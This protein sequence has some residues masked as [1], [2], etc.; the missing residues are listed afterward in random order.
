MVDV[1]E[2]LDRSSVRNGVAV[3]GQPDVDA[4]PVYALATLTDPASPV[5]WGGP[6]GKVVL[7]ATSTAVSTEPQALAVAQSLLN[8]RLGLARTLEI[9][10]VPN[11]ALEPDDQIVI[12]FPDGRSETQVINHIEIP[13]SAEGS[14]RVATTNRSQADLEPVH[15]L[16]T[17]QGEAAWHELQA[18]DV[19]LV[20]G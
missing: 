13:L 19:Q 7:I 9:D 16:Q 3:R 20:T 11:P 15:A 18:P 4:P 12:V 14:I 17:Y 1:T 2:T 8:L 5:R 10:A 6:F